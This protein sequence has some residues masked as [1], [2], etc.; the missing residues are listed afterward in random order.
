LPKVKCCLTRFSLVRV[1]SALCGTGLKIHAHWLNKEIDFENQ[2]NDDDSLF[3]QGFHSL[4]NWR[5]FP[6]PARSNITQHF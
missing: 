4:G 1:V 5:S 6:S 2:Q 3:R